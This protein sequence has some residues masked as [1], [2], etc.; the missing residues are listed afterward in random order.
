MDVCLELGQMFGGPSSNEP[1]TT[2]TA[3]EPRG[4]AAARFVYIGCCPCQLRI[5]VH[6]SSA[7]PVY[8]TAMNP[9]ETIQLAVPGLSCLCV[10]MLPV[11]ASRV[12]V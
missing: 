11:D 4:R 3:T 8:V 12:K 5:A 1:I 6:H 9:I 7:A 2:V 10:G